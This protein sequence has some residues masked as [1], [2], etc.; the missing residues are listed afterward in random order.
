MGRGIIYTSIHLYI[1][2]SYKTDTVGMGVIIYT[3]IHLYILVSYKTDTVEMGRGYLY[4]HN[5]KIKCKE[6]TKKNIYAIYNFIY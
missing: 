3:C 2:I 6:I 1:L 5:L 4:M